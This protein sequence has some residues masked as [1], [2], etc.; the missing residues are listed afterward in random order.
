LNDRAVFIRSERIIASFNSRANGFTA[1]TVRLL[2]SIIL[3]SALFPLI[4]ALILLLL[5]GS[6][7]NDRVSLHRDAPHGFVVSESR[8]TEIRVERSAQ[9]AMALVRLLAATH[10]PGLTR[11]IQELLNPEPVQS[12][13]PSTREHVTVAPSP[14]DEDESDGFASACRS[15]DGPFLVA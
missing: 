7:G 5:Q 9:R 12:D 3:A 1:L 10:D 14:P 11:L 4:P 15:R 6:T 2:A 8:R 13:A